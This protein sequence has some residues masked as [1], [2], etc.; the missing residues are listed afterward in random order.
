M[1]I[2]TDIDI[3]CLVGEDNGSRVVGLVKIFFFKLRH[4]MSTFSG[5]LLSKPTGM[6]L[7]TTRWLNKDMGV[8]KNNGIPKSSHFNRVFHYFHHPF[9]DTPIFGNTHMN[10]FFSPRLREMIFF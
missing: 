1:V 5:F 3:V 9:W 2:S 6:D 4:E 7:K 8:S 10:G